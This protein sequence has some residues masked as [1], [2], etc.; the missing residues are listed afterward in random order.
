MKKVFPILLAVLAQ[1]AQA[2]AQGSA[3]DSAATAAAAV[4]TSSTP[5]HRLKSNDQVLPRWAID[6]NYRL[7]WLSQEITLADQKAAYSPRNLTTSN[8]SEPVFRN[9]TSG[10][11]ELHLGYFFNKRR[12][13]GL[14]I[15]GAYTR[16]NGDQTIDNFKM[17]YQATDSKARVYRQIIRSNGPIREDVKITNVNVPLLLQFKH[18]FGR[19]E[20]PSNFGINAAVGPVVGLYNKTAG[21]A[22]GSLSYEAIYRLNADKTAVVS[23]FDDQLPGGNNNTSWLIT[24]AG[25][26]SG[27]EPINSLDGIFNQN[28][29]FNVGLNKGFAP[30]Q[31]ASDGKYTEIGYGGMAQLGFSYLLSYHVT[32]QLNGYAMYQRWTNTGNEGYR[33]TEKVV[34][35]AG[36]SYASYQP[37]T[38]AIQQSD[39]LTYG[40]SAGFR[41][42]FGEKRDVDGDGIPDARD[43][44]KLDFGEARFG[45]CPDRDHDNIADAEDAC[46]DEPGAEE[47][48]GC[49][50]DDHD[51]VPNKVDKCPYEFGE[52][53]DGC[54]V[55]AAVKYTPVDSGLKIENGTFLPPHV[56]LET[57]VL[58]FGYGRSDIQDSV[59]KVLDYAL[60]VLKKEEKV[61]I[62]ISGYTDDSTLR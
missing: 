42:F 27:G 11:Y 62:Y 49:P 26:Q 39:Y 34:A 5:L 13:L 8:Y 35:E 2:L 55:S 41:I 7:G 19:P 30:S 16:Y 56:V 45:G 15:G 23:G 54:P 46:P 57:D 40:V 28:Q 9:G 18:Q 48:N 21:N 25:Y 4:N 12:T 6:L 44:C 38:G 51:G 31:Q 50:D 37:V 14:S 20:K 47:T 43:K 32:F 53:R 61:I 29:G 33:F 52:L 10:S 60:R 24:E 1:G 59:A 58:Y 17:D 36:K 3:S 22:S